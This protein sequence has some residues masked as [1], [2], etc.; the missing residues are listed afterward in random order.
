VFTNDGLIPFENG[1]GVASEVLEKIFEPFFTT[2]GCGGSG[3]GLSLVRDV[4]QV[5]GGSL[6]VRSSTRAGHSGSVFMIFLPARDP[7]LG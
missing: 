6:H 7:G 1:C 4:V 3:L 5:Q 2:K